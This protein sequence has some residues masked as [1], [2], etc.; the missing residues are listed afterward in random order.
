MEK[1]INKENELNQFQKINASGYVF[2]WDENSTFVEEIIIT[3]LDKS[4]MI[5][6]NKEYDIYIK[7][8]LF[9]PTCENCKN[10]SPYLGT[11]R[12]WCEASIKQDG[13]TTVEKD[14]YCNRW[15]SK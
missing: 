6:F 3:D 9:N 2:V 11:S 4:N 8:K 14:F 12:K 13:M 7:E 5:D 1:Y 10:A 15:E